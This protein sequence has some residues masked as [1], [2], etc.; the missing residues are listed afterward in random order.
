MPSAVLSPGFQLLSLELLSLELLSL[1][2]RLLLLSRLDECS[3]DE[4]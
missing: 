1:E 3:G 4:H 2:L